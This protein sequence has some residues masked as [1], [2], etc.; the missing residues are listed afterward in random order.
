ML[1]TFRP[2]Q[3]RAP[4]RAPAVDDADVGGELGAE[5]VVQLVAAGCTFDSGAGLAAVTLSVG[6]A[7]TC[8][9]HG[10]NGSGKTTLLRLCAGLL[11]P[12]RGSR[13]SSGICLYLRPGSGGRRRQSVREALSTARALA[14]GTGLPVED[15]LDVVQLSSLATRRL[16]TL[17][18]GQRSRAVLGVA[19]CVQPALVC[20]DEPEA[21]LDEKG[22]AVLR[23]G[24]EALRARGAAVMIATQDESLLG[25]APDA[26]LHVAGGVVGRRS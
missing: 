16:E 10:A 26:R 25:S 24:V 23:D 11:S 2:S 5:P 13:S 22:V 1:A 21:H 14:D 12:T 15:A 17:S 9:V 19:L 4:D 8:L 3:Q 18:S 20:L 7:T 6:P